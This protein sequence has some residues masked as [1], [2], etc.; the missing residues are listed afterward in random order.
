[1]IIVS[2]IAGIGAGIGT[3]LVGMSAAVIISP[4]LITFCDMPAY[5]AVTVSL[6]AD[7]IASAVSAYTYGKSGHLDIKNGLVM[8]ASVVFFTVVGSWLATFIPNFLLG[9]FSFLMT[10]FMGI[11]FLVN[12]DTKTV[13]KMEE[14]STRQRVTRSILTGIPIGLICGFVGAGGGVMMLVMLVAVLGYPLKTAVGTSTFIMSFTAATGALSHM[15]LGG[16]PS[17]VALLICMVTAPIASHYASR[18]ANRID[19]KRLNRVV[20]IVLVV[21]GAVMALFNLI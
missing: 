14:L 1:M 10:I 9:S 15:A 13:S 12:P 8:M 6:S 16:T 21:F 19:E 5:E 11:N 7:V 4:M 3:G 18:F 20:G 2:I 17:I